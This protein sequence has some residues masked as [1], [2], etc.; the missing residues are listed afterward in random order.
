MLLYDVCVCVHIYIYIYIHTD[1]HCYGVV[2]CAMSALY[3]SG[4]G[5][6]D[7]RWS[8]FSSVQLS[9]T[10]EHAPQK[11]TT[12]NTTDITSTYNYNNGVNKSCSVLPLL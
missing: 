6:L 5:S 4:R 8:M 12:I 10:T 11:N 2:Y 9:G 7:K 1:I 3:L